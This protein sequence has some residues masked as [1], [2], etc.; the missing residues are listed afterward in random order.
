MMAKRA[1]LYARVSG[2]DRNNEDRNLKGQLDMG[3]EHATKR[4]WLIVAELAEDDRGASGAAFELPQLNRI[5]DMAQ[6]GEFDILVVRELDRLS[7]SLAKQ[8]LVEQELK[9]CGIEIEYVLGEYPDT[10]E[11]NLMKN[12]K[13][14]IAEYERLK[15]SERMERGKQL[16][17]KAGSVMVASRPPF[18]YQVIERDRKQVL[19]VVESE[20]AIVRMIFDW[21]T[22]GDGVHQPM[23]QRGI[24]KHLNEL[25]I[26]T[27]AD[28]RLH[29]ATK[30]RGWAQ[31][32]Q[33]SIRGILNN[34]TYVGRW[35]Y[36][37]FTTRGSHQ[38]RRPNGG[39]LS[40]A[41][42]PIIGPEIW[43][44][45]QQRLMENREKSPR[46]L[47]YEYL[48][49]QRLHCGT[50]G[51]KVGCDPARG[52]KLY[53]YYRCKATG[54]TPL[55][56][57]A[58]TCDL[59]NFRVDQ[60]EP[61]LWAWI[62]SL[63]TD[64]VQLV[65]GINAI[66]SDREQ[67]LSPVRDRL[68]AVEALLADNQNQLQRLIDLYVAGA[69]PMEMLQERKAKLEKTLGELNRER[70]ELS[71]RLEE[72]KMTPE[73]IRDLQEFA[74][75]IAKKLELADNNFAARKQVV[76]LLDVHGTLAIV[77]DQKIFDAQCLF[78]DT[79]LPIVNTNSPA[80]AGRTPA[81]RPGS[82]PR[83]APS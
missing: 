33:S 79:K 41:V 54:R 38:V 82:A 14:S 13:A 45:A 10:P 67:E 80:H 78:G 44:L 52:A 12:L 64:P 76:E 50:C 48:L 26:P 8:L 40:V 25:A 71:A 24:Q 49:N 17:I 73:R 7:R 65:E 22:A 4:G 28:L 30:K 57:Y 34:T 42:P 43:D 68:K 21:Y 63:L 46:N 69:F 19:E 27:P 11:G 72:R 55:L 16:K 3:R 39:L 18:G 53:H 51:A 20:A 2:D 1:V 60:V 58:H 29:W 47:K 56:D 37:K 75:E 5:R 59:P 32:S 23:T 62:K 35:E 83:G 81:S 6:A 70:S 9:H 31:W 74:A 77:A 36:S 61:K 15:I 66:Q